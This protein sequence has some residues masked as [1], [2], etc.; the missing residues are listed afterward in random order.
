MSEAIPLTR[1]MIN[2]LS[3]I[4]EDLV[5]DFL[6]AAEAKDITKTLIR[7]MR[8]LMGPRAPLTT[9]RELNDAERDLLDKFHYSVVKKYEAIAP[10]LA[11]KYKAHIPLINVM[12]KNFVSATGLPFTG[13]MPTDGSVGIQEITPT[14]LKYDASLVVGY[15]AN[16]W[17]I[18][19]TT[20]INYLLGSATALYKPLSNAGSRAALVIIDAFINDISAPL[21]PIYAA[22]IKIG[23]VTH[24][25]IPL[26]PEAAFVKDAH[27]DLYIQP[28]DLPTIVVDYNTGAYLAVYSNTDTSLKIPLFGVIIFE[29][30]I[31]KNLGL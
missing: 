20:G 31:L 26:N 9:F 24:P 6:K 5:P 4:P 16:S 22:K 1:L 29:S 25:V 8:I 2:E 18:S 21:S 27:N 19:L 28:L 10:F 14:M 11:E 13:S 12:L 15:D 30:S 7:H 3:A 17:N 23:E